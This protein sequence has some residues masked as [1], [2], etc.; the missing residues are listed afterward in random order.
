M[1]RIRF[2]MTGDPLFLGGASPEEVRGHDER[3]TPLPEH[4]EQDDRYREGKQEEPGRR[5]ETQRMIPL[6]R[7]CWRTRSSNGVSVVVRK[8]PSP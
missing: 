6:S 8:C 2:R 4:P 7:R 1:L 3:L 5:E